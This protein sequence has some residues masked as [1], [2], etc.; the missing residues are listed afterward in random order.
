[1][2]A[3]RAVGAD[4]AGMMAFRGA[5]VTRPARR[6]NLG[7]RL[8]TDCGLV[9]EDIMVNCSLLCF[10]LLAGAGRSQEAAEWKKLKGTWKI[11]ILDSDGERFE[12]GF[13]SFDSRPE[14]GTQ[15]VSL[16]K[17]SQLA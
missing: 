2:I 3:E 14:K 12:R 1:L 13:S 8:L 16:D 15:L 10:C 17:K 7:V 6:L 5:Q 9:S 11:V 4:R